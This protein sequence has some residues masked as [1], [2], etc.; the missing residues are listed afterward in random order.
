MILLIG[1]TIF[2]STAHG[3]DL[4]P[5]QPCLPEYLFTNDKLIHLLPEPILDDFQQM[6]VQFSSKASKS[7]MMISRRD[8]RTNN[9][10]MHNSQRLIK[11]KDRCALLIHPEDAKEKGIVDRGKAFLKS[12]VGELKVDVVITEDVMRGVVCLPHGWGHDREGIALR[13]AQTNPGVSMN[14]LTDDQ[15]V[16]SLSGNAIFNGVPVEIAPC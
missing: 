12:R 7:L 14:D 3:L 10:W 16:D 1:T 15:R 4:G 11:G 6:K 13:V 9:S 2:I 5:L 8:L